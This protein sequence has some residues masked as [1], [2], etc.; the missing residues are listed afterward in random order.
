MDRKLKAYYRKQRLLGLMAV[1]LSVLSIFIDMDGTWAIL[2]VP[3]GL[4]LMFTK[5]RV[6][7]D[8]EIETDFD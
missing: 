6:L 5:E 8:P 2:G 7:T 1:V 3:L 4:W